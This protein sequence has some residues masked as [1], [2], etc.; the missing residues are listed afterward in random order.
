[1]GT[2][3]RPV[4]ADGM[5]WYEVRI[6]PDDLKGW[7]AA[8][9]DKD[10]LRIIQDGAIAFHCEGCGAAPALVSI[11][12]FG[13]ADIT[14]MAGDE[15]RDWRWS[16]DGARLALTVAGGV[17]S[18]VVVMNADGSDRR[19]V[20][21]GGYAPSWSPDGSRL[22]WSRETDL[23]VTDEE[24][25][26]TALGLDLR[27]AGTPFWSPDGGRLAFG[28]VDCAACPDDE[29]IVGDPPTAI[30]TVNVDGSGLRQV[31]GGNYD[32]IGSWSP[33]GGRL[34][35]L[36][37]DLSGEFPTRAFTMSPDGGE[38]AFLLDGSAIHS[39]PAW[40]PDGNFMAL[41]T[42][43]GLVLTSGDGADLGVLVPSSDAVIIG[44]VHWSPSGTDRKSTRL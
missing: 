9:P 18:S 38:P 39:A 32:N 6:G 25:V 40:S 22:A 35:M 30:F 15:G 31:A 42:P 41:A 2:V 16:P 19:E 1:M 28:A 29:P 33:D 36:R 21:P 23:V 27:S 11:T 5:D 26:P 13:D 17:T 34:S 8:G 3:S 37:H 20:G 7:I 44:E 4:A 12:P 14:A 10:W 43:D 24:L